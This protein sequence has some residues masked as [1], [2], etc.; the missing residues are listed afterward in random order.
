MSDAE[1]S[2]LVGNMAN[3]IARRR[4]SEANGYGGGLKVS[5]YTT[6]VVQGKNGRIIKVHSN[7]NI[8]IDPNVKVPKG[9]YTSKNFQSAMRRNNINK[10][11]K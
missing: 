2:K 3:N 4:A 7:G 9:K 10:K 11:K 6:Q 1:I 5:G 8:G